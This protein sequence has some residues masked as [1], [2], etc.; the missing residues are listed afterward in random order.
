MDAE[1]PQRNPVFDK[2]RSYPDDFSS[3][4]APCRHNPI[5][6]EELTASKSA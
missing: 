1:C 6:A 5:L 4:N 3:N 2:P